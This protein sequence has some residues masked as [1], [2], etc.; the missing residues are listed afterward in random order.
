MIIDTRITV[1]VYIQYIYIY[2]YCVCARA[3]MPG[4]IF[5]EFKHALMLWAMVA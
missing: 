5:R 1:C 3:C 2:N 4:K